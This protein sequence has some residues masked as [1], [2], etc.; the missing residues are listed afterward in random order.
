[1][2]AADIRRGVFDGA[3]YRG[4]NLVERRGIEFGLLGANAHGIDADAVEGARKA[5][6]CLVAFRPD[7]VDD[8]LRA[9]AERRQI[10]D[11]A[12]EQ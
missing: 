2:E 3:R 7:R 6:Q 11:T 9:L 10:R 4:G 1:V 12:R 5:P 8:R